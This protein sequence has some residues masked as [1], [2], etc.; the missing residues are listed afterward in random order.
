VVDLFSGTG[1]LSLGAARA[2]FAVCGAVELDPKA[3]ASHRLNFPNTIHL[4]R[5]AATLE[6]KELRSKIGLVNGDL[7]GIIG[8]PPCQ[9]FSCIGRND[10]NDPRNELFVHFFRIVSEAL[11][12]FFL[13]ENV[14]GIMNEK[15]D[16]I[17]AEAFGLIEKGY[18][19]LPPM[20]LA[21][22]AYGAPTTR[23]RVFFIGFR[24]D[25]MEQLSAEDFKATGDAETVR[26]RTALRGLPVRINPLWQKEEEGWRRVTAA[27]TGYFGS[28]LHGHVPGGV[29]NATAIR[30]LR[31]ESR[32][33]GCLG[34]IHTEEVSR[35]YALIPQ[36]MC[37]SVSKSRRLD[38]DGFCPTLRAGTGPDRGRY[39]AVRPL[40]PT[41]NRV[42]TPREAARLQGFP[43][44]FQF[45]PTKW[46]SFR[47][48]GNSV[49]PILAE[50]VLTIIRKA[51]GT[52]RSEGERP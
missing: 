24:S 4:E 12:K 9:G 13:A 51:I 38:P 8:G 1:G 7:A 29:G 35:R 22:H 5:D 10:K 26:V 47:Q 48:I 39:Q 16:G 46:H 2:G 3:M 40:H 11:P 49:S 28:R 27:G 21:A 6:G 17:R 31:L 37:D 45:S 41:E 14:P 19:V 20:K 25:E 52:G 23:T 44:W 32:A 18:V 15:N 34:T 36:G 50:R 33:S 42:I 30:R 43:D